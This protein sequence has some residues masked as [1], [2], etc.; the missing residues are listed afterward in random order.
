MEY[1]PTRKRKISIAIGLMF[2]CLLTGSCQKIEVDIPDIASTASMTVSTPY[3][4]SEE[5]KDQFLSEIKT[6][7]GCELPCVLGFTPGIIEQDDALARLIQEFPAYE[8]EK[9]MIKKVSIEEYHGFNA[10]LW[11]ENSFTH[12]NFGYEN[13]ELLNTSTTIDNIYFGAGQRSAISND[14]GEELFG[15]PLYQET[16]NY[17]SSYHILK[18]YGPP[19]LIVLDLNQYDGQGKEPYPDTMKLGYFYA[20]QNFYIE[21]YFLA[22]YT[23]G[24]IN[25]CPHLGSFGVMTWAMTDDPNRKLFYQNEYIDSLKD[26]P[27]YVEFEVASGMSQEHYFN[28]MSGEENNR[29]I[30]ISNDYWVGE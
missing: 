13:V 5:R 30:V 29:C 22:D 3:L 4:T 19:T 25:L 9:V 11:H 17:Y 12:L 8:D 7:S 14:G 6:N 23:D 26:I 2:L 10:I 16:T 24:G 28:V 18:T 1:L 27:R 20:D 15:T 21:Y